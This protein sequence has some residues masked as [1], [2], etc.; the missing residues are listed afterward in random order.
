MDSLSALDPLAWDPEVLREHPAYA[1]GQAL[2]CLYQGNKQAATSYPLS[3]RLYLS[4]SGWLLLSVPN[5]LVRGVYDAMP[6][7]GAELPTTASMGVGE[8]SELLNAHITVMT[9]DEVTQVG[10]DKINERGHMFGYTLGSL[11]EIEPRSG[12]SLSKIWAIQVAAPLLS[13]LRKSY[14]LSALPNDDEPFHITV[15]VRKRGVL[16]DNGK[17]KG[18][19]T[20]TDINNGESFERPISRGELKAAAVYKLEGDVQGVSLRKNL[21]Q[22][23]DELQHPGLAYNNAHT[24]EVRAIISGNQKRRDAVLNL[25]RQRLSDRAKENEARA[26]K[27]FKQKRPLQ[28]GVDYKITPMPKQREPMHKVVMTPEAV[29]NFVQ[30][31]GFNR[32]AAETPD[33]QKQWLSDRYRLQQDETGN[34]IGAVPNLAKKQLLSGEPVYNYQ[35]EPGWQDKKAAFPAANAVMNAVGQGAQNFGKSIGLKGVAKGFNAAR[36]AFRGPITTLGDT[37]PDGIF[38]TERQQALQAGNDFLKS[39]KPKG[40]QTYAGRVKAPDSIAG[41]GGTQITD[42]MLGFRL[43]SQRGYGQSAVDE[44]TK[45]LTDH[46]VTVDRAK[47]LTKPG[48]HGWNIKG[49]YNN[50][51]VEFQMSPRRLQGLNAADH[52]LAYKP[53]ESGVIPAIGK[54]FYRPILGYGMTVASPMTPVKKR[55][56]YGGAGLAGAAGVAGTGAVASGA[57]PSPTTPVSPLQLKAAKDSGITYDCGCSGRCTCPDTCVCKTTGCGA[58]KAAADCESSSRAIAT[59]VSNERK[60]TDNNQA[61]KEIA[62]DHL[63]KDPQRS[64]KEKLIEQLPAKIASVYMQQLKNLANFREPIVYDE[65]KPVYQNVADHVLKAKQR[66]DHILRGRQNVH[67]YRAM[68]DPNYRYQ[69]AMQAVDGTLPQMDPLD[70]TVQMYGNDIFDMIGNLGKKKNG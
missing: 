48:Y 55:L 28:E 43:S 67:N 36:S 47:M 58:Q 16:L 12:S 69:V 39:F 38:Q 10:A 17:A 6:A 50:T 29:Q 7:P 4:K 5:A 19:E 57:I 70:K 21:H 53:H 46:G 18:Y 62:A 2:G 45:H 23:L 65:S 51:P 40:F 59:G 26:G 49:T 20:S 56:A 60:P 30:Q 35:L 64:K 1:A 63:S 42:D 13:A 34:L 14:G 32:L 41:H 44:L 68:L 25:L 33:Y 22:I 52:S 54:N 11:K 61:A 66:G 24:G 3:G 31:Q 9:G 8:K 15:A 37:V 27:Q